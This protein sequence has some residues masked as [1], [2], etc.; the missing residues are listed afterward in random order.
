[1][2]LPPVL[3]RARMVEVDGRYRLD[4]VTVD[5][6]PHARAAL[7]ALSV[8]LYRDLKAVLT[9]VAVERKTRL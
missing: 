5:D 6:G 2:D 8:A 3:I 7:K 1:M 4:W 9:T